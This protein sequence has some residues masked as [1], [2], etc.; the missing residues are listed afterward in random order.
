MQ[1][2]LT[3]VLVCLVG[4]ALSL[5][6]CA[7]RAGA[8]SLPLGTVGSV[9]STSCG[10]LVTPPPG[11]TG[12]YYRDFD[13]S[14]TNCFTATL[15]CP[16]VNGIGLLADPMQFV[17]AYAPNAKGTT[18]LGTIVMF[19][20]DG[21]EMAG[22]QGFQMYY[23][24]QYELAGYQVV[25]VAWGPY[26]T[27]G[28]AW[29]IANSNPN[30]TTKPSI[31]YAACR[32]ATF[33]HYVKTS[34]IWTTGG[35]CAHADS[36]G[37]AAVAYSM[38]WYGEAVD[39]NK[40]LFE[41]GPVF[42]NINSGCVVPNNQYTTICAPN[43]TQTGCNTVTW[44]TVNGNPI[45]YSLEFIGGD[46]SSVDKWTGNAA[47]NPTAPCGGSNPTNY[48]TQW[49]N[50]SIVGGSAPGYSATFNYPHTAMSAW[51]C[52]SPSNPGAVL[53][54]SA[55]EG[56]LYYAQFTQQSQAG[57]L[58][59]LNGVVCPFSEDIEEGIT[60]YNGQV[61][62]SR[63]AYQALI[64]DMTEGPTSCSATSGN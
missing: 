12:N 33:L 7:E 3:V 44:P 25:E 17:Y 35:M 19:S 56:G 18:L 31:L 2:K 34:G 64:N 49:S 24:P 55:A 23:V 62:D 16:S 47:I 54:N 40:V 29:E 8:Q 46:A 53:N 27:K 51:L 39:V 37:S 5:L 6:L 63:N 21:G 38:A 15:T 20:G 48:S 42:S 57:N 60:T 11:G 61:F 32:Q 28:L 10:P 30:S 36:G 14:M 13:P 9:A 50:M 4:L 1:S 59:S 45:Q 58:M 22:N 41:N 43:T 52:Q 26:G